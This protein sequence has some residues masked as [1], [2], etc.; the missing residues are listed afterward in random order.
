MKKRSKKGFTLAELLI[1]VA[2]IGVLVAIMFPVFGAQLNKARLAADLANVRAAYSE[3][4]ANAM[5]GTAT[6]IT[7]STSG[8]GEDGK[9]TI[10][11]SALT[12]VLKYA[13]ATDLT[14]NTTEH[15]VKLE[16]KGY[17]GSFEYDEDVTIA[18]TPV[19]PG[20]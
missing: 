14:V 5:L 1:V 6:D 7:A 13:T 8:V 16:Y 15:T 11:K 17:E 19:T 10:Q 3:E 18:E 12:D 4:V 9:I 20:P 2:I